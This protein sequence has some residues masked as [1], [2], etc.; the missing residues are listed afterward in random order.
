[1]SAAAGD[2][3]DLQLIESFRV[4]VPSG[5]AMLTFQP[6]EP[7]CVES[8]TNLVFVLKTPNLFNGTVE[9][10]P[11]GA[12]YRAG[13]GVAVGAYPSNVF[14]LAA[15][16]GGTQFG[17]VGANSYQWPVIVNGTAGSCSTGGNDCPADL[18]G[19]NV[20]N[21]FDLSA[22]LAGWGSP[23][24]DTNGDGTTNGIDITT[25]LSAWNTTCP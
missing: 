4:L 24:G 3:N 19:D 10:V 23:A 1:V 7:I 2:G 22:V 21:G 6:D 15:L 16:C 14:T 11:A 12:G 17:A 8:E 25:I 20:V 9:G 5:V 13:I 18:N